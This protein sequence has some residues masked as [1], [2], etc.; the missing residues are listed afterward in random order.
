MNA[1]MVDGH[2]ETFTY[3][4]QTRVPSLLRRNV[5]VNP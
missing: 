3:N 4:K 2:V 1:L 5:Y